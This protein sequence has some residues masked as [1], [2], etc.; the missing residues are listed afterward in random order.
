M[1]TIFHK[2]IFSIFFFFLL[3]T[4]LS[5]QKPYTSGQFEIK[6]TIDKTEKANLEKY[7]TKKSNLNKSKKTNHYVFNDSLVA[8]VTLDSLGLLIRRDVYNYNSQERVIISREQGSY[9]HRKFKIKVKDL[10]KHLIHSK[11]DLTKN[12]MV[13]YDKI[14]EEIIEGIKV[15]KLPVFQIMNKSHGD[16]VYYYTSEI[17]LPF[18]K[19]VRPKASN[20]IDSNLVI[21]R[22]TYQNSRTIW[23]DRI[24]TNFSNEIKNPEWLDESVE[25]IPNM[26]TFRFDPAKD[27]FSVR[28]RKK[29]KKSLL[30]KIPNASK[31]VNAAIE[32]MNDNR[33]DRTNYQGFEKG[34]NVGKLYLLLNTWE[35]KDDENAVSK[36]IN[37][38]FGAGLISQEDVDFLT[39]AFKENKHWDRKKRR[40]FY[41]L[42]FLGQTLKDLDFRK[43]IIENF[44]N[45]GHS[46]SSKNGE[47]FQFLS[48]MIGIDKMFASDRR[49]FLTPFPKEIP[50]N[51]K[52]LIDEIIHAIE[53][54]LVSQNIDYK[55]HRDLKAYN[56]IIESKGIAYKIDLSYYRNA[57]EEK[58]GKIMMDKYIL[59]GAVASLKQLAADQGLEFVYGTYDWLKVLMSTYLFDQ[60]VYDEF[61]SQYPELKLVSAPTYIIAMPKKDYWTAP[62]RIDV[63][64]HPSEKKEEDIAYSFSTMIGV[65]PAGIDYITSDQKVKFLKHI[66]KYK[67]EYKLKKQDLTSIEKELAD[68]LFTDIYDVLYQVPGINMSLPRFEDE[69]LQIDPKNNDFKDVFPELN[70]LIRGDFKAKNLKVDP[71]SKYLVEMDYKGK[72][73]GVEFV[74]NSVLKS[75]IKFLNEQLESK[76]TGIYKFQRLASYNTSYLYLSN[77]QRDELEQIFNFRLKKLK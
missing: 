38:L 77:E 58:D 54:I 6:T 72:R 27:P 40:K 76:G 62:L 18:M 48:G 41:D 71:L 12:V 7:D 57:F 23:T 16:K 69:S 60:D 64:F 4:S 17:E 74:E 42:Y 14:E 51:P 3:L 29:A 67:K 59:E 30:A 5:S 2:S 56:I 35:K 9:Y 50:A 53:P 26:S 61:V 36:K 39:D 45:E 66:H 1:N 15:T 70:N 47:E 24:I 28:K 20:V 75:I 13:G 44:T 21:R 11:I 8:S 37:A 73:L 49:I 68:N 52:L 55:I 22:R 63:E 43:N 65:V 19:Y 10:S 25:G 46:F 34:G 32:L 31:E 33:F